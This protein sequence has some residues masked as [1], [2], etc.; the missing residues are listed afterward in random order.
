M[1]CFLHSLSLSQWN[2]ISIAFVVFG[3]I[4]PLHTASSIALC[5]C[6]GVGGVACPISF[7]II[8]MYMSLRD[9]VYSDASLS[10]VADV[11]MFLIMWAMLRIAPLFCGIVA[12]LDKNNWPP[13]PLLAFG[14]Q[15]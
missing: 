3:R 14:S 12:F 6:N 5:V 15:G 11:M 4:L 9:M 13:A 7:S 10:S 1:N 2:R 8:Q